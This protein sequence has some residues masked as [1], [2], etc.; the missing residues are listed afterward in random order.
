MTK[1]T[2]STVSQSELVLANFADFAESLCDP[3]LSL[4]IEFDAEVIHDSI[5]FELTVDDVVSIS[6]DILSGSHRIHT[7]I[8]PAGSQRNRLCFSMRGKSPND[9]VLS[10]GVIV[11]DTHIKFTKF[12]INR[13]DMLTDYDFFR[14]HFK[15][16]TADDV[17][18][19]PQPGFWNNSSLV[20]DFAMPFE[21]WYQTKTTKNTQV[22]A[23]LEH[24][25][26]G[27]LSSARDRFIRSLDLLKS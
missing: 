11:K 21:L 6:Q 17:N 8:P 16:I 1:S 23:S 12:T 22:A 13:F 19:D 4:Q 15:S 27:D 20:L 26:S 2:G 9:T 10:N 5:V 7:R 25:A 18:Q 24:Q 14:E 3:I